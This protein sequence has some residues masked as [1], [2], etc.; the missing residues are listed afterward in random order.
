M[1]AAAAW[2]EPRLEVDK[3]SYEIFS[4][5]ESEFL[6]DDHKLLLR[7]TPAAP[8]A[9]CAVASRVRVL[10]VDAAEGVITGAT[11]ARLEASLRKQSGDP[12]ACV[13]DFFDLAAGSGSGG[14]LVAL[15]FTRGPDGR[16]LFSAAEALRLLAKHR[17]HLVSGARRKGI[18]GGL[19]CRSG[20]LLRRVF[21]NTTLRDTLKPVLIPCYDLAT[22]AT[23]VF[24]RAD[25]V[26]ADG[27][28]FR[29][30]EVC[31]ATCA[32]PTAVEVR[33]VDGRTMIRAVGGRLAMGNPTAAAVTHVL[34]NRHEFPT[35]GG[36]EDLL[37]VSIG[38]AEAPAP[39][40][41]A[42]ALLSEAELVRIASSVHADVV[43]QA[44]ATAFGEC[45]ATNYVR[46]EGN[47]AVPGT[48]TAAA[49]GEG[50][51]R[52]RGVESVLFRE[53]KLSERTNE[54]KLNLFAA[55][56]I[57]EQERRKQSTVPAVALKTSVTPFESSSSSTATSA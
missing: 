28:D 8:A 5:L 52:E 56:L 46:I 55:E 23:I 11:L 31:A 54:E 16:P 33:S 26:E 40:G 32:G 14:V 21:G 47:G 53:R 10:S 41:K 57:K 2:M 48:T 30:E 4:M 17:R 7:S 9:S 35:A 50:M 49:A 27:Y 51:L 29:M 25:A 43:D 38:G 22:G 1:S 3:L 37:V 34:N 12:D 42:R 15:L 36:V 44:V 24:S 20:G 45:R 18:L 39:H 19:L 6:Y 13:A